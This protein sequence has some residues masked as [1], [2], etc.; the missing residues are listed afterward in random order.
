[1]AQ[2]AR[3]TLY[4]LLI[5]TALVTSFSHQPRLEVCHQHRRGLKTPAHMEVR[6][7][8][9]F[10]HP[11]T[12]RGPLPRVELINGLE[13]RGEVVPRESPHSHTATSSQAA[14]TD[15]VTAGHP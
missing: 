7:D 14:Q 8:G 11:Y 12:P 9:D 4:Q 2:H 5:I 15:F 10:G 13:A 3:R 1:M 6:A